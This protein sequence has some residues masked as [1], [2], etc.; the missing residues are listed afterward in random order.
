MGVMPLLPPAPMG[1]PCA[2]C[3]LTQNMIDGFG[4]SGPEGVFR[5][6]CEITLDVL[7]RHRGTILSIMDTFV[8]D[9]LVE[10]TRA[11][12]VNDEGCENPHARDALATVEGRLRGTLLGVSSQPCMPLSVEGHAHRLIAEAVDKENLG[13]MY[14]WCVGL[15]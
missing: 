13:L 14:I 15:G 11:G 9:P 3:R 6:T 12:R 7:R 1:P 5:R 8:N 10:W 2:C 4:V